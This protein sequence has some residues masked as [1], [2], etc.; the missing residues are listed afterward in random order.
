M[1]SIPKDYCEKI[2]EPIEKEIM[3]LNVKIHSRN[4]KNI[5]LRGV[6]KIYLQRYEKLLIDCYQ[7][8]ERLL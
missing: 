2:I 5:M 6:Y 4:I 3:L 8:V 7:K 1:K